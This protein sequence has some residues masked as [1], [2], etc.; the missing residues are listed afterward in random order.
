[1]KF[2]LREFR[3]YFC[4]VVSEE[5]AQHGWN[6]EEHSDLYDLLHRPDLIDTLLRTCSSAFR[7][8]KYCANHLDAVFPTSCEL[9]LTINESKVSFQY[10]PLL[11][12][13]Q[14][15]I[16]TGN[17][18]NLIIGEQLQS[19]DEEYFDYTSGSEFKNH[20]VF[21]KHRIC[22]RLHLYIDDFEV[23]NPLGSKKSIHKLC[24]VYFT[25]G[26]LGPKFTSKLKHIF[27]SILCRT[28]FLQDENISYQDI[29]KPL[30]HDLKLLASEGITVEVNG[31][32]MQIFGAVTT[33][34]A[35]NLGAHQLARFTKSFSSGRV[36]RFCMILHNQLSDIL[37]EDECQ[38][39]SKASHASHLR[40]VSENP[41]LAKS[42]YR[43]LTKCPLEDLVYF[44][45]VDHFAPDLMHDFLEGVAPVLIRLILTHCHQKRYVRL[46]VVNEELKSFPFGSCDKKSKPTE[47]PSKCVTDD[48]LS[49]SRE[50]NREMVLVQNT[51][52]FDFQ[53]HSKT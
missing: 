30:I 49:P 31:H 36:C 19:S 10:V 9:P 43:V 37:C 7:L 21:S 29:L 6:I 23:V 34:S 40:I 1:M 11:Q 4:E 47:I 16:T 41:D 14:K 5:T 33:V 39:R 42:T 13:L 8:Q 28:K 25:L 20:P 53:V 2:I 46:N 18:L 26:N 3:Q 35:D 44:S 50:S 24:A 27:L 52:T 48:C 51:A 22:L 32:K 12:T 45:A 38:L 15:I 17:I